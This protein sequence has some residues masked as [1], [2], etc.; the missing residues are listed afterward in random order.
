MKLG[1]G[2]SNLPKRFFQKRSAE[3][4]PAT[5]IFVQSADLPE[6]PVPRH[7]RHADQEADSGRGP[8]R[9]RQVVQ[10]HGPRRTHRTSHH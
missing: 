9:L 3:V 2:N 4:A 8:T 5:G 7:Q 10:R 1:D 6:E